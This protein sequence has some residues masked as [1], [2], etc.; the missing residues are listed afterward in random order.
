MYVQHSTA[1]VIDKSTRQD[2]HEAGQDNEVRL[3]SIQR[4]DQCRV[5]ERSLRIILMPDAFSAD[6]SFARA[7]EP[8]SV[9]PIT[10]HH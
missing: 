8:G 7:L 5:K 6:V 4:L 9:R 2:A 10:Q 1:E 3:I